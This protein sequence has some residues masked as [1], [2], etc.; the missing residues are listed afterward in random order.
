MFNCLENHLDCW[1][2]ICRN[3]SHKERATL[4]LTSKEIRSAVD[5][6][7]CLIAQEVCSPQMNSD[8]QLSRELWALSI[9]RPTVIQGHQPGQ[10]LQEVCE[11]ERMLARLEH[12]TSTFSQAM[13]ADQ[14][15]RRVHGAYLQNMVACFGTKVPRK[16]SETDEAYVAPG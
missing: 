11:S 2:L 12:V 3:L 9:D 5:C 6:A 7:I 15:F 4:R 13:T 10:L 1:N 16:A 8:D 14:A